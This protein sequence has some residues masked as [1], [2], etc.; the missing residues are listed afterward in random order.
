MERA[1]RR[2]QRRKKRRVVKKIGV[3]E[4]SLGKGHNYFTLVYDLGEPNV[5][6]IADERRKER[7]DGYF[8]LFSLAKRKEIEP[9]ATDI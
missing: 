7:L 6:Y 1:V 4:K 9:I 5:K 3:D 2:G 8:S